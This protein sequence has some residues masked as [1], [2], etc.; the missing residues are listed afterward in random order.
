MEDTNAQNVN[1]IIADPDRRVRQEFK[2][3]FFCQG[4][5]EIN[6]TDEMSVVCEAIAGNRVDRL[7]CNA[8]FTDRDAWQ[9]NGQIRHH[10]IGNNP[11]VVIITLVWIAN[12]GGAR[13]RP[14]GR[15]LVH[16]VDAVEW[17]P[18]IDQTAMSP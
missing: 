11:F 3:V 2:N 1:V 13:H 8:E 17:E 14:L 7:I 15:L 12:D 18:G 4:F 9:V 16:L 6:G 5:R 10:A